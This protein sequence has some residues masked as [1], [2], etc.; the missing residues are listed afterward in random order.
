MGFYKVI[1][2]CHLAFG[3]DMF[4]STKYKAVVLLCFQLSLIFL[5][6]SQ[7]S[8]EQK[9]RWRFGFGTSVISDNDPMGVLYGQ[10]DTADGDSG[11][12]QYLLNVDY[13]LKTI[14]LYIN[15]KAYPLNLEIVS[16]LGLV[17]ENNRDPFLNCNSAM[18]LRWTQFPWNRRLFTTLMTGLGLNYS[19]K[20]YMLDTMKHPNEHRS[21]L[22][23]FWP[24]E[25]TFSLVKYKNHQLVFF[26]HH[27]SGGWIMD[28]GG[29]DFFGIGY[30]YYFD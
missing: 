24:L 22:K 30:R 14:D 11:G 13:I 7:S 8:A 26:N 12:R 20:I 1:D 4:C 17:D 10:F 2:L 25:I 29:I 19:E 28:E 18:G 5:F 16:S 3:D 15:G 23:F 27:I 6:I 21:H 9:K